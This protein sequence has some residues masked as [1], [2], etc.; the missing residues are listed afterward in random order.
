MAA[1]AVCGSDYLDATEGGAGVKDHCYTEL[2]L[3]TNASVSVIGCSRIGGRKLMNR[4]LMYYAFF[5]LHL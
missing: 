4:A 5:T 3:A 2:V 1:Q